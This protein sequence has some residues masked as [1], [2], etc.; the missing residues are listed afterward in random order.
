MTQ[1]PTAPQNLFDELRLVHGMLRRDLRTCRE[2]AEAALAGAPAHAIRAELDRLA[3]R[4]PLFQL[5]VTCLRYCRV[6][7]AHHG[8][9]DAMLLPAVRRAAPHLGEAV[10]RL[11]ADHR[12]VA[13]VLDE[14]EAAAQALDAGAD[15]AARTRLSEALTALSDHLLEHL[16]FEEES[17]GPVLATWTQWPRA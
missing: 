10:D 5:K 6:V 3:N 8:I 2:L 7:H 16:D 17:I 4:G 12:T 15:T 1:T 9:E 13:A 11:E 14:V